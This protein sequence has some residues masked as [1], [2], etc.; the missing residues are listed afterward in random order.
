MPKKCKDPVCPA[1]KNSIVWVEIITDHEYFNFEGWLLLHCLSSFSKTPKT[2]SKRSK[3]KDKAHPSTS[4]CRSRKRS[5]CSWSKKRSRSRERRS[6]TPS[7]TKFCKK[8]R[9]L[10]SIITITATILFLLSEQKSKTENRKRDWGRWP[11]SL[12][13]LRNP[14]SYTITR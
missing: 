10:F 3:H 12:H 6:R 4:R 1:N 13:R 9:P 14:P 5:K 8:Y 11:H 2:R 7:Y